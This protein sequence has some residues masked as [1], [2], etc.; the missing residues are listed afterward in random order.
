[1]NERDVFEKMNEY[2]VLPEI[3]DR[4]MQSAYAQLPEAGT[5]KKTKKK[6]IKA[7]AV[8]VLLTAA[9][10]GTAYAAARFHLPGL[11]DPMLVE[12]ESDIPNMIVSVEES[13]QA[14]EES[15]PDA[16]SW[17][18]EGGMNEAGEKLFNVTEAYFDGGRLYVYAASTPE[19][20]GYDLFT[21]RF[22]VDGEQ[23]PCR[24]EAADGDGEYYGYINLDPE[25]AGSD[26]RVE[27]PLNYYAEGRLEGVQTAVFNV[28][29]KDGMVKN[30]SAGKYEVPGG[31]ADLQVCA[32]SR[33]VLHVKFTWHL[34]GDR[35][36]EIM[37]ELGK[38]CFDV[39]DD[40]GAVHDLMLCSAGSPDGQ[41]MMMDSPVA[42]E[43]GEY[44]VEKDFY[45]SGIPFETDHLKILPY[46]ITFDKEGKT[47]KGKV[48]E[49]YGFTVSFR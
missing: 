48:F 46:E 45:C 13:D 9:A 27:I 36:E 19:G 32:L 49:D 12:K 31:Y 47:G 2:F 18:D 4:A 38:A 29:A 16:L 7:A 15:L 41:G 11:M 33:S 10:G 23:Y 20:L 30:A 24:F 1:M 44:T 25:K 39:T 40:T 8:L 28:S 3:V 37:E 43:N 21:D 17:A 42:F 26:I 14:V 35:A 6:W 5:D 34:S 22:I